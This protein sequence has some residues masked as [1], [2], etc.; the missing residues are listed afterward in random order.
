M[1]VT[2]RQFHLPPCRNISAALP[3]M[4]CRTQSDAVV[5]L[6]ED[7]IRETEEIFSDRVC[8]G[9]F[10]L[11]IDGESVDLTF[12]R[13][14][15]RSLS[16]HLKNDASVLV[17]AA[18]VGLEIDRLIAKY[19]RTSPARALALQAVGTERVERLCDTF[20]ES[21]RIQYETV[22]LVTR[23]RFSPGYGDLSLELQKD[24]LR[25]LDCPRRIGLTLNDSLLMSPTKSVTAI[26][27]LREREIV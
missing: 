13:V 14:N 12:A 7:V 17:F 1:T 9:E 24:I 26:V 16:K 25:V 20:C 18:T 3:Y 11:L 23:A 10:D 2:V 4:G 8:Y 21:M 6:L 15:S 5:A 22:D 19:S 27:G